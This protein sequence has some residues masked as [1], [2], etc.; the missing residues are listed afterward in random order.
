MSFKAS[1]QFFLAIFNPI[2]RSPGEVEACLDLFRNVQ[3]S[4]SDFFRGSMK[5]AF[6][7]VDQHTVSID[8]LVKQFSSTTERLAVP[9]ISNTQI[10]C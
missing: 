3:K 2:Y 4:I 7:S 9:T 6:K 8:A 5:S 1:T 10:I